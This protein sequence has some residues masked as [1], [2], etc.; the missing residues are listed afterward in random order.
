[1][2]TRL[3]CPHCGAVNY[4]IR[5][6]EAPDQLSCGRCGRR[7]LHRTTIYTNV[8]GGAAVGAVIGTALGGVVGAILGAVIGAIL[9]AYPD[10]AE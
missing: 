6:T 7:D 4:D 1:M 3:D 10:P 9:A 8:V 2:R 5:P